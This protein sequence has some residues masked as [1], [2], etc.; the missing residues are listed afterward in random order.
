MPFGRK[1]PKAFELSYAY[2][3]RSNAAETRKGVISLIVL[4]FVFATMGVFARYLSTS[5]ELFEQTYLR[6]GFAFLLGVVLFYKDINW[7][8]L[9]AL[10]RRDVGILIFRAITLYLGVTLF[11][12]A[13]LHTKYGNASFVS[14]LP[15]LPLFGYI[16][17][18]ERLSLRTIT[19]IGI[20]FIGILFITITDF[21]HLTVGYGELMALLSMLAFDFSY[22]ARRWHSDYLNNKESTVFMFVAGAIFLFAT[23]LALGEGLPTPDQFTL[24]IIGTLLLAAL[25]NVA[26]L[27]LTNYGFERVKVGVAGNILTLETVFALLY[28]LFLFGESPLLREYIGG[29]LVVLSVYLVN[30]QESN[31]L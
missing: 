25:F 10:P 23:S 1:V 12:E 19:Y 14:T 5:F 9:R 22:I 28:S 30:R 4:A 31:P 18:K 8:K 13:I 6:I 15:L 24:I 16:F 21:D 26:N 27:Y 3:M 11:T 2:A 7:S 29:T 20:G 17:L